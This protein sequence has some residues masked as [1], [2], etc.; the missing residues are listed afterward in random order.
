MEIARLSSIIDGPAHGPRDN[1]S[2]GSPSECSC[3]VR[4]M[5]IKRLHE[6][7]ACLGLRHPREHGLDSWEELKGELPHMLDHI[8]GINKQL[9]VL[10]DPE[11][12]MSRTSSRA[13]TAHRR[14]QSDPQNL[15]TT[16]FSRD[17]RPR[18]SSPT[19]SNISV[20]RDSLSAVDAGNRAGKRRSKGTGYFSNQGGRNK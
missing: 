20:S 13:S 3:E 16:S 10:D 12:P 11:S 19:E 18:P 17:V 4:L 2:E 1:F 15:R 14:H 8:R 9:K 7:I 6:A 5:H